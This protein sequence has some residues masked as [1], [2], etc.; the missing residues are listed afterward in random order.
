M[1][2]FRNGRL[3]MAKITSGNNKKNIPSVDEQ[4]QN[5]LLKIIKET[6]KAY[7]KKYP[8]T[9]LEPKSVED[10]RSQLQ[11]MS[12]KIREK[13]TNN[14]ELDLILPDNLDPELRKTINSD[15]KIKYGIK[16]GST[17]TSFTYTMAIDKDGFEAGCRAAEAEVKK[18]KNVIG[19]VGILNNLDILQNAYMLGA[20][21]VAFAEVKEDNHPTFYSRVGLL[22][23]SIQNDLDKVFNPK[24]LEGSTLSVE[25]AEKI[26]HTYP[27]ATLDT[28]QTKQIIKEM[29]WQDGQD[30]GTIFKNNQ[31]VFEKYSTSNLQTLH[32]L[33]ESGLA[34]GL[35][36]N[37]V[38][39]E[40]SD[41]YI[42]KKIKVINKP[43]D[44]TQL[45]TLKTQVEGLIANN[46]RD[47]MGKNVAQ[48]LSQQ[49]SSSQTVA[50]NSTAS[51]SSTSSVSTPPSSQV[52]RGSI[53][54]IK[55]DE[56]S[57]E[58]KSEGVSSSSSSR[59]N[60]T[61]SDQSDRSEV[62]TSSREASPRQPQPQPAQPVVTDPSQE[63][64]KPR[65]R[66]T[67]VRENT[68]KPQPKQPDTATI[69]AVNTT[70]VAEKEKTS[71][72]SAP[73]APPS[74]DG[75]VVLTSS[76]QKAAITE[77]DDALAGLVTGSSPKEKDRRDPS[78]VGKGA[79]LI[80]GTEPDAEK[81]PEVAKETR[82]KLHEVIDPLKQ[83]KITDQEA[84]KPA[85]QA[86]LDKD[87][88]LDI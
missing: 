52:G 33:L 26:W 16:F 18:S 74:R 73:P 36:T 82:K 24:N 55:I 86:D 75:R 38:K 17:M 9:I 35:L 63:T 7:R 29:K 3:T 23:T 87:K 61:R 56:I 34:E 53:P 64:F 78:P 2:I 39:Q 49:K 88:S 40:V 51:V 14:G 46:G 65:S 43:L 13:M 76:A 8:F 45:A 79:R 72:K 68:Y 11:E 31:S 28:K 54:K 22:A 10:K 12:K 27:F 59:S 41:N 80:A 84:A 50:P 21:T 57:S 67:A 47:D 15:I 69:Q 20:H 58:E 25:L 66:A 5:N 1:I 4:F 70:P 83:N 6:E 37:N 48:N 71:E 85:K 44:A 30:A 77:I 62:A 60:S 19:E 81:R 42:G 32:N